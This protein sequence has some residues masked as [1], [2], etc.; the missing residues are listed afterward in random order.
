[1]ATKC[2]GCQ[3]RAKGLRGGTNEGKGEGGK[4]GRGEGGRKEGE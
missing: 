2:A 1:M 3:G 4:E